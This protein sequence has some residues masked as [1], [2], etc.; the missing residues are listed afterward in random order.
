MEAFNVT[1]ASDPRLSGSS[2]YGLIMISVI[3]ITVLAIISPIISFVRYRQEYK[4]MVRALVV[5]RIGQR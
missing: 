1:T 3:A 5:G 4:K 2:Q